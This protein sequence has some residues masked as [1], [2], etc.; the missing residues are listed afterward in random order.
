MGFSKIRKTALEAPDK[1]S[2][3]SYLDINYHFG[4]LAEIDYNKI[5]KLIKQEFDV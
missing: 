3:L 1:K 2:A 4:N 5:K